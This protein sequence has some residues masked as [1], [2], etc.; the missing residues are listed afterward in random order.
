MFNFSILSLIAE[1]DN[2]LFQ[3]PANCSNSSI[4][5]KAK[6]NNA[7][8]E[9]LKSA[10][11][12]SN[13]LDSEISKSIL[14][15][16]TSS[17][18][19]F[20]Q[21][22]LGQESKEHLAYRGNR[23][24]SECTL[25]KLAICLLVQETNLTLHGDEGTYEVQTGSLDSY[26]N[27]DGTASECINLLPPKNNSVASVVGG[28]SCN[29]SI[30]GVLNKTKT[31]M[32]ARLLETWLRQ[33]LV[34]K[35]K[36][37]ERHDVVEMMVAHESGRNKLRNTGLKGLCDLD[38]LCDRIQ[39]GKGGSSASLEQL[40]LIYLF[41][42]QQLPMVIEAIEELLEESQAENKM[43]MNTFT[44]GLKESYI[45]LENMKELVK[46]VLDF[47]AAP[48][49]FLVRADFDER[50]IELKQDLDKIDVELRHIHNEM[51]NEWSETSGQSIGQVRLE[52]VS[53][54][55]GGCCWQFRLP[56]TNDEKILRTSLSHR[57][58]VHRL[59]KNGVYF[60]TKELRELGTQKQDVMMEYTN[61][62]KGIVQNAMEVAATYIPV[63][64][65]S[66][67]ILSQIDVLASFAFVAAYSPN[68]YCRPIMTDSNDDNSGIMIEK[69]RHPCV[70]LQDGVD[71]I[72]NDFNLVYNSSSF[73]L[74]TGPNMGGKSTYIR[75]L[76]AIVTMAQV[77]AFVP[78]ERAI[79]NVVDKIL[80]R[81]GA[82]DAQQK[83]ISTFMA[84]M[85]EASSILKRATKRSLII[86]DELG[87]GTSTFD[88]YGL[89]WAISEYI[90]KNI[91]AIT[92]FATHFHELTRLEESQKC[93]KNYH[94]T[95][96]NN[97]GGCELTFLY[98]VRPGPCLESFGIKVAEMANV[99]SSVIL[100]AKRK[101]SDLEN[102]NYHPNKK[103]RSLKSQQGEP[104]F[105]T[106]FK[107][108]NLPSIKNKSE[109]INAI[110]NLLQ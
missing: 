71:F 16:P 108:I 58:N 11:S 72:P 94:V 84:E 99:P 63:L 32:G 101:A 109:R 47:D 89:A 25:S 73:I 29:N 5:Q 56:K 27:L 14:S 65:K 64:E 12:I 77:G 59:L 98:E 50:L 3:A 4:L 103:S 86:I 26:L 17:L 35:V 110:L 67:I 105:A 34:D 31:K 21:H 48:Q 85:L 19:S 61:K 7:L 87:R 51:N 57:V 20:M 82:G 2:T 95:A 46:A 62:Q 24:L 30:Y 93:V 107:N 33:P 45:A 91:G 36:I 39:G 53:T 69:G 96:H 92:L 80:A 13:I 10:I 66:S 70:E 18:D 52:N 22:L 43:M 76:G 79:I 55:G 40:Y 100:E 88:G 9:K 104:S 54:D 75:S 6:E 8:F 41:A 49:S 106:R 81:V 42:D 68:T 1:V 38:K 90:V 37:D 28:N 83:G 44:E 78:A 97:R 102:F 23:A 15:D 74:L 60:S